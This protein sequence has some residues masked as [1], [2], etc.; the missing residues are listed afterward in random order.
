MSAQAP[1]TT[2]EPMASALPGTFQV[3]RARNADD[4]TALIEQHGIQIV[5][6]RFTDLPGLWQHF[7]IAL[8]EVTPGLFSEGIGFDGS[9]IRVGWATERSS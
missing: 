7:S 5:D 8:P 2:H 6:L 9:S 3:T 4:V 1:S